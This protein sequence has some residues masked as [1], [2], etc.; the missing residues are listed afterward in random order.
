MLLTIVVGTD[1][2]WEATLLRTEYI[3]PNPRLADVKTSRR[4]AF[5]ARRA[6]LTLVKASHDAQ[7]GP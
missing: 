1:G 5:R 7:V 4:L 3:L 2:R 6:Q